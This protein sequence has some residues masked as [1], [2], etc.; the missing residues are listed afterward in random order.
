M[1]PQ[2]SFTALRLPV[3]MPS[4]PMT[5]VAVPSHVLWIESLKSSPICRW[6][7]RQ[8]SAPSYSEIASCASD[9]DDISGVVSDT[10]D[11][12]AVD[13][14][15][16]TTAPSP[17]TSVATA[18]A[19]PAIIMTASSAIIIVVLL[20]IANNLLYYIIRSSCTLSKKSVSLTSLSIRP[21]TKPAVYRNTDQFDTVPDRIH[22][23]TVPDTI[24]QSVQPNLCGIMRVTSLPSYIASVFIS[25]PFLN[26]VHVPAAIDSPRDV[27]ISVKPPFL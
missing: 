8:F 18:F 27:L 7:T 24:R 13:T 15:S 14:V 26:F 22:Q 5:F 25:I 9:A 17:L 16:L 11:A 19:A 20:F 3:S 12:D 2:N 6:H 21:Y 10:S 4:F 23:Q 1:V